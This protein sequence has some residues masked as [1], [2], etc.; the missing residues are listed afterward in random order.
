M[1]PKD[2]NGLS[3]LGHHGRDDGVEGLLAGTYGIGVA[4]LE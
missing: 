4:L 1:T 3:A 2:M